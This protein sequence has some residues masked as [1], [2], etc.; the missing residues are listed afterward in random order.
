[1]R[2]QWRNILSAVS[3]AFVLLLLTQTGQG[4]A[5][6]PLKFFKNY[7]VTGDYAVGGVGLA[8][9]GV[10]GIAQGDIEIQG[11]PPGAEVMAA[12]LICASGVKPRSRGWRHRRD[13]PRCSPQY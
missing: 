6:E 12:F 13:V 8:A 4:Q 11:V 9:Q 3:F 2:I 5:P 7:F 1:M 10:N